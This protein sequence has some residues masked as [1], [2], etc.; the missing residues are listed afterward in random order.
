[1]ADANGAGLV[2]FAY[3]GS[4][5]AKSAIQEAAQQL[6]PGRKA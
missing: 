6:S 4:D 5:Q 1:M 2:L 3:D